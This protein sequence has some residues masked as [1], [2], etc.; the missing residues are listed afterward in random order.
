MSL[1]AQPKKEKRRIVPILV[2]EKEKKMPTE[3]L[4]NVKLP[5][6]YVSMEPSK[7]HQE[8]LDYASSKDY[9]KELEERAVKKGYEKPK[10]KKTV[11]REIGRAHV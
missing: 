8:F 11:K 5:K 3:L 1:N 6:K 7:Y 4:N 2:V 10:K 9:M